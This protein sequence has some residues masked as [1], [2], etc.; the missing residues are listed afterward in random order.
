MRKKQEKNEI[1]RKTLKEETIL[2]S[3]LL[4]LV[5]VV[6]NGLLSRKE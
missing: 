3:L 2:F 6:V 1:P 4:D 5:A